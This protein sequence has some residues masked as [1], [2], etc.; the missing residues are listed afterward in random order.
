MKRKTFSNEYKIS[1][2]KLVLEESYETKQAVRLL[3]IHP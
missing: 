2:A 1:A 3:N